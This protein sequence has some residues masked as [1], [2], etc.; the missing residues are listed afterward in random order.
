MPPG[1][2]APLRDDSIGA[3]RR[4]PGQRA[5][6]RGRQFDA[7]AHPP[8]PARII[9]AT[10]TFAVEQLAADIGEMDVAIVLV[11]ELD[12]A[13]APATVAKALPFGRRHLLEG[14]GPPERLV[15]GGRPRHRFSLCKMRASMRRQGFLQRNGGSY[16]MAAAA[17]APWPRAGPGNA[18]WPQLY[19][20]LRRQGEDAREP[21]SKKSRTSRFVAMLGRAFLALDAFIDS[22][23]FRSRRRVI[24]AY[25]SYSHFLDRFH[26]SGVRKGRRRNRL[27][28]PDAGSGRVACPRSRSPC[29][30]FARPARRTG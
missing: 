9:R 5:H 17:Q 26:V 23:L 10:A 18:A 11:F 29:P 7:I 27:R 3:G 22:S 15:V 14:L 28:G 2:I 6:R 24:A 4:Q 19:A 1:E 21:V 12:E 30:P 8:A 13:T 20:S 16:S 25:A